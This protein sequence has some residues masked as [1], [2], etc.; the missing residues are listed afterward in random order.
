MSSRQTQG[1]TLVEI[2]IALIII[3]LLLGGILRASE[4][5]TTAR[6]RGL[7]FATGRNQGRVLR[8]PGA[9]PRDPG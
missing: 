2:A 5:I 1:F 3:G 9:F 6:V 8:L 7:N 4:L